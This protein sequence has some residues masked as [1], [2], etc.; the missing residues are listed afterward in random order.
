MHPAFL[1]HAQPRGARLGGRTPGPWEQ[2]HISVVARPPSL[3]CKHRA[4]GK[5]QGWGASALH[6]LPCQTSGLVFWLHSVA[7]ESG[8]KCLL[9]TW[10]SAT[11]VGEY[12]SL[13]YADARPW[14]VLLRELRGELALP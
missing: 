11:P 10:L 3:V 9:R 2:G 14:G 8:K 5:A 4:P 13:S 7:G 1:P 12:G 6:R